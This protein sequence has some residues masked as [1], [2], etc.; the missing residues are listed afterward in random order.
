MLTNAINAAKPLVGQGLPKLELTRTVGVVVK[1][2]TIRVAGGNK[3][4]AANTVP[5]IK[6]REVRA[7]RVNT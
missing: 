4:R 3:R 7:E 5:I 2:L 1:Q 6:R